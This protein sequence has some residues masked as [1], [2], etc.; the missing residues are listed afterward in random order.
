MRSSLLRFTMVMAL[1]AMGSSAALAG[2][3]QFRISSIVTPDGRVATDVNDINASGQMLA[4]FGD[5]RYLVDSDF[6]VIRK[7]GGAS[8][9]DSGQAGYVGIN[10]AGQSLSNT[11]LQ[12]PGGE[13]QAR[14]ILISGNGEKMLGLPSEASS[15][16]SMSLNNHG[17]VVGYMGFNNSEPG[18]SNEFWMA[19]FVYSGGEVKVIPG[20]PGATRTTARSINDQGQVVGDGFYG[21]EAAFLYENGRTISLGTLVGGE[22]SGALDINNLGYVVGW[23]ETGLDPLRP[24]DFTATLYSEGVLL[25]LQSLIPA[26]SGWVLSR[27]KAINDSNQIVGYGYYQGERRAFLLTPTTMASVP[28]PTTL[29]TMLLGAIMVGIGKLLRH[30]RRIL[31]HP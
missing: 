12:L 14:T 4:V 26:D 22:S 30:R 3:M 6:S 27:A 17:D 25:D 20:L 23:S 19:G 31:L 18:A 15:M 16:T 11:I 2:P 5:E 9:N 29:A 24:L 13:Y 1:A 7:Q 28:E 8:L 10:N 21:T